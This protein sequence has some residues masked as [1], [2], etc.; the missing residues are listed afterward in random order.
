MPIGMVFAETVTYMGYTVVLKLLL[1]ATIDWTVVHLNGIFRQ[2]YTI[3]WFF[4]EL[5][6]MLQ[7]IITST[8]K[9]LLSNF[10]TVEL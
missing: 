2:M 7:Y 4:Q 6:I 1:I 3:Q 5:S 9:C 8:N 10:I